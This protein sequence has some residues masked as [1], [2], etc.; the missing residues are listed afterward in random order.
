VS[1]T[2]IGTP[3]ARSRSMATI[4]PAWS[5]V[6]SPFNVARRAPKGAS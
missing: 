6:K 5:T 4:N 2:D 1:N 3:P